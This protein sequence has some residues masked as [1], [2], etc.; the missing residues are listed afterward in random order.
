MHKDFGDNNTLGND[1]LRF[2]KRLKLSDCKHKS[3]EERVVCAIDKSQ[4]V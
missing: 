3:N 2:G 1:K 4:G